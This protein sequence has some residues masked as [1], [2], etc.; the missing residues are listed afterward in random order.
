MDIAARSSARLTSL[1]VGAGLVF[2]QYPAKS[3]P[4]AEIVQRRAFLE[5]IRK[6]ALSWTFGLPAKRHREPPLRP[7]DFPKAL[8]PR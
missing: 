4:R 5:G 6:L 2:A 7:F 3:H 1:A 8:F